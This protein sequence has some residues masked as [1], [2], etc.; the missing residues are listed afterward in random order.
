MGG[1]PR[2][3]L[4]P[5]GGR[6]PGRVRVL[7]LSRRR[8]RGHGRGTV[9]RCRGRGVVSGT[10][11]QILDW[12]LCRTRGQLLG[13]IFCRRIPGRFR[14]GTLVRV[15]SGILGRV[16]EITNV[17][18]LAGGIAPEELFAA[19]PPGVELKHPGVSGVGAPLAVEPPAPARAPRRRRGGM[20]RHRVV[21]VPVL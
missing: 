4:I 15:L 12:S 20:D 6:L 19:L 3:R 18:V 13:R 21:A 9:G 8:G 14:T 17:N 1:I 10:L 11:G 5:P 16:S 2:G 7:L